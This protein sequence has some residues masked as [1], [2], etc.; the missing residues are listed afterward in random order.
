[1]L[2]RSAPF[3]PGDKIT[4]KDVVPAFFNGT[5]YVNTCTTSS[6]TFDS[7]RVGTYGSAGTVSGTPH[8]VPYPA[9]TTTFDI[10]P[11]YS[12]TSIN[13]PATGAGYVV[14]NEIL[15][16]G[17]DLGGVDGD[18]DLIFTVT[19]VDGVGGIESAFY[20]G[21]ANLLAMGN[22]YPNVSGTNITGIGTLA[23]WDIDVVPGVPTIFDGGSM[24]FNDP[25]NADTSSQAFDRYLLYPKRNILE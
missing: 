6:V 15:I 16:L 7:D 12:T 8:W 24:Q 23:A 3:E 10:E 17:S 2:F 13:Y 18:N 14:G 4:V 9:T 19:Q 21:Q 25:S 22:T 11:H 20:S 1:M 5:F